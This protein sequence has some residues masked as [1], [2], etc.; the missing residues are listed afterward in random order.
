MT[1]QFRAS[2]KSRQRYTSAKFILVRFT[3]FEVK[4]KNRNELKTTPGKQKRQ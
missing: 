2:Y 1:E 4:Y 3:T